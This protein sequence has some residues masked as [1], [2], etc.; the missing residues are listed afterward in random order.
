MSNM[1]PKL[2]S[3]EPDLLR[4]M[5][6]L[7]LRG[8]SD[9]EKVERAELKNLVGVYPTPSQAVV[10]RQAIKRLRDNT[11]GKGQPANPVQR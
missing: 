1:P 9:L 8:Q 4:A 5:E 7:G 2:P 3:A 10:W 11:D 6:L